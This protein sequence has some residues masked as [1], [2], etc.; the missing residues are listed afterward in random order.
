MKFYLTVNPHGGAKKG[1]KILNK[2]KPIFENAEIDLKIIETM[3]AGHAK[4]LAEQLDFTGFDGLIAIGGDGTLHEI[5][6]GLMTR[7]DNKDIPIGLI[8][9]G[10]GNSF[11]HD[12]ELIDPIKAA[13]AIISGKTKNVDIAKIN[14]NH[15]TKYAINIIG[16]GL[17]TDIANKAEKFRWLGTSRYTILS[18]LEVFTYNPRSATIIID[19]EKISDDFTFVIACNTIHTG[20]GMKMAPK[21]KLDDGKIDI[22]VVKHKASR[23]KLLSMLPTVFEGTHINNPLVEYYRASKFSLIPKED[24][25][26]NIDGQIAGSTPINVCVIPNKIKIYCK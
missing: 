7:K 18:V 1:Q 26:L 6:N 8:P 17:V 23:L 14:I 9:G 21:A 12:L 3:Y 11:M 5:I 15:I 10:S 20:K 24:D 13:N 19:D 4:E 22:I 25:I 2:V 16:W